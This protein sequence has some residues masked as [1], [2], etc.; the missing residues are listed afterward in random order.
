MTKGQIKS[1]H[2]YMLLESIAADGV[3]TVETEMDDT[4]LWHMPLKNISEMA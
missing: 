3:I 1:R 2:S 4:P